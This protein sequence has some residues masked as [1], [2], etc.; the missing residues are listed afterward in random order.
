MLKDGLTLHYRSGEVQ[1]VSHDGE[2]VR[3]ARGHSSALCGSTG[4]LYTIDNTTLYRTAA[5][6][7]NVPMSIGTG[8]IDLISLEDGQ[9]IGVSSDMT[10]SLTK[11]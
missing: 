7:A 10:L 8:W 9:V 6:M 11:K 3:Q 1:A 5:D 4:T 2:V